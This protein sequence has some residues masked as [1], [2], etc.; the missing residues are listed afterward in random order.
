MSCRI[1][2]NVCSHSDYVCILVVIRSS[3]KH[4]LKHVTPPPAIIRPRSYCKKWWRNALLPRHPQPRGAHMPEP[5]DYATLDD[6]AFTVAAPLPLR[7]A[8]RCVRA[9]PAVGPGQSYT[10]ADLRP[11]PAA[12]AQARRL[13]RAA[14]TCW[15]LN[16][17]ADEV[18]TIASELATRPR[19]G[20]RPRT[21]HRRRSHRMELGMVGNPP[22]RRQG[23]LGCPPPEP[24]PHDGQPSVDTRPEPIR[25]P[26]WQRK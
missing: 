24:R 12:A 3:L 17:L 25:T 15:Q 22:H 26:T 1:A 20:S 4:P 7:L 11:D 18:E 13:T 6:P 5:I 21:C 10:R 16:H 8:G 23:R 19:R 14:L 9:P 2:T